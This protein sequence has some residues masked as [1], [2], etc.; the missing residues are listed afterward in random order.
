MK[1]VVKKKILIVDDDPGDIKL[2]KK[3][4]G[5]RYVVIEA[6]DALSAVKMAATKQP[7]LVFLDVMMPNISGYT[8]CANLKG[9][10]Y[11]ENI[12]VVMVTGHGTDIDKSI[13]EGM[14]ANG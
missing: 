2:L 10:P 7:D 11:T 3:I 12:P 1:K 14:S 6:Q 9:N 5:S 4:I 13:R 8:V